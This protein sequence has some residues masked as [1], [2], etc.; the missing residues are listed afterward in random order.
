WDQQLPADHSDQL[1]RPTPVPHIWQISPHLYKYS[2]SG[3][4]PN[5]TM[6]L[7]DR[8]RALLVDFGC[9][10]GD[11]WWER[12]FDQMRER[13]GLKGIDA[14]IITH[15]HGDHIVQCPYLRQRF[16]TQIWTLDRIAEQFE[17]P[18]RFDYTC[19]I[20]AYG[21]PEGIAVDRTFRPGETLH[22]EGFT[23]TFDWLPGQTEFG[24]CVHGEVDGQHVAWTGDNVYAS[25]DDSGHDAVIA[26]NSGIFEEGY[27][28]CAEYLCALQ[29]DLILAGH[30]SVIPHPA[31]QL[32]RF[33][34]WAY[35]ARD[36]FRALSPD[37][38]YRWFFD[39]YW[40]RP[41]PYRSWVS[42]G[43]ECVLSLFIRRFGDGPHR[44]R[45]EACL[46]EGWT[47]HPRVVEDAGE[48][49]GVTPHRVVVRVPADA[50][51]GVRLVTFDVERN[52]VRLG[53]RFEA[54]VAVT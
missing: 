7:S 48:G 46:P 51:P 16:G 52:G 50:T 13:L 20:Q 36:A 12:A 37:G 42:P 43:T 25:R 6:I 19:P 29:P 38:D 9:L 34:Q 8:G 10:P 33:R 4:G 2:G 30:S 24:L 32:E 26:R 21:G 17:H 14:V 54:L 45:V 53:E 31:P 27:I 44:C 23:F 41:Y 28:Y 35:R 3:F 1:S 22:W 47:A 18:E 5:F 49:E 39:P 11:A 40:V 15:M